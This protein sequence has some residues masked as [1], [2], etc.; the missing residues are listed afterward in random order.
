MSAPTT[1]QRLGRVSQASTPSTHT[2]SPTSPIQLTP[3][4]KVRALLAAFSDGSED[5]SGPVPRKVSESARMALQGEPSTPAA[6]PLTLDSSDNEDVARKPRGRLASRMLAQKSNSD[7]DQER[8]SQSAC[9]N[10]RLFGGLTASAKASKASLP[11]SPTS[12]RY[13]SDSDEAEPARPL[14]R[15]LA[16]SS[17]SREAE[18][19]TRIVRKS[20][21]GLFVS[22]GPISNDLSPPRSPNSG[23]LDSAERDSDSDLPENLA[24]NARFLDLVKLKRRE[25]LAKEAEAAQKKKLTQSRRKDS[26]SQGDDGESSDNDIGQR[27]TQQARPTRK[28]SKKALEEMHRETQRMARN[29]QL[30]HEARTKKKI[31]KQSLFEKFNYK[32]EQ[33]DTRSSGVDLN[34]SFPPRCSS[35]ALDSDVEHVHSTPPTSPAPRDD[36][37]PPKQDP[38]VVEAGV[39]TPMAKSIAITG[40]VQTAN[41]LAVDNRAYPDSAPVLPQGDHFHPTLVAGDEETITKVDKGKGK[42]VEPPEDSSIILTGIG[43][44]ISAKPHLK[45][46]LPKWVQA[47]GFDSDDD[48]EIVREAKPK[49]YAVFDKPTKQG[50][51]QSNS[52]HTLRLLAQLTSPGK[53]NARSQSI[54]PAELQSDL[55]RRARQQALR[56]REERLQ[57]LRDRGIV[58]PTA[59]ERAKDAEEAEDLVARARKEAEAIMRREKAAARKERKEMGELDP[60]EECSTGEDEDWAD[61]EEQGEFELSGSEEGDGEGDVEEDGQLSGQDEEGES[62]SGAVFLDG[63][64]SEYDDQNDEN[65]EVEVVSAPKRRKG[66]PTRIISDD[67]DGDM[68]DLPTTP[69]SKA[70]PNR[71]IIPGLPVDSTAPLGLTQMFAATMG[72]SQMEG[73]EISQQAQDSLTLLR[74]LSA[75]S[76]PDFD[77]IGFGDSQEIIED[78]QTDR[79]ETQS[80]NHEFSGPGIDLQYSQSQVQ[81]DTLVESVPVLA[82]Q[83]SEFPDPSQDT[84][85][86]KNSPIKRRFILTQSSLSDVRRELD[87]TVVTETIGSPTTR[88]KGRLR[89]RVEVQVFSDEEEN[90]KDED[91]DEDEG[92][93]IESNAF[94]VMRKASKKKHAV[95]DSFDKA[96]SEAKAMVDEQAQESE[97]EYAGLG[98]ASDDDSG[99]EEDAAQMMDMINDE[100]TVVNEREIAAFYADKERASDEKQVEKLFKDITN[101]ILRRKRGAD[102][103]LSDSDDDL[104]ARR[105]RKQREFAKMRKALLEDE[106][107]GKIATNPKKLAFLRAIED[108]DQDEQLDFLDDTADA[109]QDPVESQDSADRRPAPATANT[110][111]KRNSESTSG[112]NDENRPPAHH[113][114]SKRPCTL[115]EI[116]ESLSSLIAEPHAAFSPSDNQDL[117]DDGDDGDGESNSRNSSPTKH[118]RPNIPAIDRVAAKRSESSISESTKLAFHS[119]T[120]SAGGFRVPALL[121]RVATSHLGTSGGAKGGDA[122]MV[123]ERMAGAGERGA[124]GGVAVKRGGKASS[125]INF[126]QRE[127]GR[128]E[129]VLETEKR[130]RKKMFKEQV[131]G[132]REGIV[133]LFAGGKFD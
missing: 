55:R 59:E 80:Q 122:V 126:H 78:S 121:R 44:A 16:G 35:S 20:S 25:R 119:N 103:D 81:Y 13:D 102:F 49:K 84:G 4:S 8:D 86:Q 123:T 130:R 105:R 93:E 34:N 90:A 108:H 32:P 15:R 27:L 97:D 3:R 85:F 54:T 127:R 1:P 68:P 57:Q 21:P 42:A 29:M 113:R 67:E 70:K 28:A 62:T 99:N 101:G 125:S 41:L 58:V 2:R 74:D 23:G 33:Q 64:A 24:A 65:E 7:D 10:E 26:Y 129:G 124:G 118:R 12:N 38:G 106:N 14:R 131:E 96:K 39:S 9:G 87:P 83:V 46:H 104:E 92:F 132:R 111:R 71:Q 48:L 6:R 47:G 110:K 100:K 107:L 31:T 128:K 82:T 56:D 63:E 116:R 77:P 11:T 114:K 115:A 91:G 72:D 51:H 22:P 37:S 60:L 36:D 66:V 75:P 98:G 117:S 61:D 79:I 5:D 40:P 43:K 73:A 50:E 95:L 18:T 88:R 17:G 112:V 30:A 19:P 53:R 76:L 120:T 94:D 69:P 133:G 109:S 89:R 52:L 45:V